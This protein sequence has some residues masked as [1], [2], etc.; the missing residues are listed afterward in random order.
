MVEVDP[1]PCSDRTMIFKPSKCPE[2]LCTLKVLPLAPGYLVPRQR[3]L[4]HL[5]RSYELMRQTKS[6]P[7]ISVSLIRSVFAGCRHS[8]LGVGPSRRYL[9][10]SFSTCMDPYSG[11]SCGACTR[12]F[13]Q[14]IG[15]PGDINRSA[16]GNTHAMATS[17]CV[18]FRSCSHSIIFMPVNLLATQVAPTVI[19]LGIR[20]PWLLLPR[21]SQFV[22]SLSRGYANRPFRATG[23]EGTFTLLDS[24]PCR[25]LQCPF[26][27]LL[28]LRTTC[29]S[30]L[31]CCAGAK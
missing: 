7:S 2:P 31:R 1:T 18:V 21:I 6:L 27:E 9:R 10:E 3:A 19:P 12:F 29:R 13:P 24:R 23:G 5:H 4:P 17:A 8:L 22:A 20:Q 28:N 14:N 15:L 25:P 11:C 26:L 30:E 16:L